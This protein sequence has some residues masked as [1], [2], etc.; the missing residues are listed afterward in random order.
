MTLSQTFNFFA[1]NRFMHIR[2][3]QFTFNIK[4][5]DFNILSLLSSLPILLC[6]KTRIIANM[7]YCKLQV[8]SKN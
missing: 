7:T 8:N 5:V 3:C 2:F 6:K 1:L 4:Y